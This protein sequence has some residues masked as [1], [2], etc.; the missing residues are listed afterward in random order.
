MAKE[1]V[2]IDGVYQEVDETHHA[3]SQHTVNSEEDIRKNKSDEIRTERNSLLSETDWMAG[4]DITMPDAWKTYRQT[5]RD[6]TTHE[7][8]PDTF[9]IE[10]DFP[11]KPS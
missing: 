8:F 9:D 1:T 4:S 2:M 5:L 10:S 3:H 6:I 11:T 7:N